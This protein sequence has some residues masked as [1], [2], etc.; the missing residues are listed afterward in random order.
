MLRNCPQ[1][2]LVY[3][4]EPGYFTGAMYVSYAMAVPVVA[5]LC[6]LVSLLRPQWSFEGI[7]T[8]AA[9]LFLPFVPVIFRYSRIIWIHLDRAIDAGE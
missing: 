3:E 5:L 4:R 1:C 6:L 8:A 9:I 2:G 7:L